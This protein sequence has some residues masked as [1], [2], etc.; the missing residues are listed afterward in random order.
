MDR[1]LLLDSENQFM[2]FNMAMGQIVFFKDKDAAIATIEHALARG[3]PNVVTLVAND[4]N[5]DGL[6][7]DE[8]FQTMLESAKARVGAA[9]D[10]MMA[11]EASSQPHAQ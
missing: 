9:R 2:R 5:L 1:A 10:S 11:R 3:G 6:R 7:D 4:P 8:R